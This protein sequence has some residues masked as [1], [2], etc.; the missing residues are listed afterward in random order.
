MGV[1]KI[2]SI[3]LHFQGYER[4]IAVYAIPHRQGILLIE[5]G[6]GSTLPALETGL[7]DHGYRLA[8]ITDIFV[9]HIH[10]DHAGAAGRLSQSG[11]RIHVHQR[12]LPHLQKPDRLLESARRIYLDKMDTLWG[13]TLPVPE[14]RLDPLSDEQQ[15]EIGGVRLT[16]YDT[17]GHA[18]H[19]LIY[20][21]EG[22]AF[23]GDVGGVRLPGPPFL[24]LP[25]PPPEFHL[26]SWRQSVE[27]LRKL[28]PDWIAP[29]HFGLY[30]D[31]GM[32]LAILEKALESAE[33]WMSKTLPALG[34]TES[35][36]DRLT[37]WT[38]QM[39]EQAGLDDRQIEAYEQVNPSWTSAM[40]VQRYWE[41]YRST[42]AIPGR[43]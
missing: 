33:V 42:A 23:T 15:I 9:T 12:G 3:D 36:A 25:M 26:E 35:L 18:T 31:S 4:T 30:P 39:A 32:H 7:S 34:L 41:K 19:H 37:D 8:D 24:L 29:T 22:I 10:L 13:E 6:P 21:H 5:C 2:I 14:E 27:R 28:N 1:D 38:H 11:A 43:T 17:P 40:G 16:A 20:V